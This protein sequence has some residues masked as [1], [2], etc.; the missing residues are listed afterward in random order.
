MRIAPR[1]A[2]LVA[3]QVRGLNVNEA[4][5]VLAY[6][7]NRSAP[8]LAKTLKSAVA[9]AENNFGLDSNQLFIA[10]AFVDDGPRLRRLRAKSRGRAGYYRHRMSHITVVVD[11][12]ES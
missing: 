1:K 4:F 8:M 7:P 2:R 11:E 9:N 3:D 5:A 10:R 12:R 6:V